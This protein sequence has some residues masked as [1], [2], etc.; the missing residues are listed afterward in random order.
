MINKK[1]IDDRIIDKMYNIKESCFVI[2]TSIG[3]LTIEKKDLQNSKDK[4]EYY[5]IEMKM[6][7]YKEDGKLFSTYYYLHR[8]YTGI[9]EYGGYGNRYIEYSIDIPNFEVFKNLNIDTY[10]YSRK[11]DEEICLYLNIEKTKY[12]SIKSDGVRLYDG[13]FVDE[14]YDIKDG[15]LAKIDNNYVSIDLKTSDIYININN[16]NLKIKIDKD[17]EEKFEMIT[18]KIDG[19]KKYVNTYMKDIKDILNIDFDLKDSM[20]KIINMKDCVKI[21]DEL[22]NARKIYLDGM[23]ILNYKHNPEIKREIAS[24]LNKYYSAKKTLVAN[25]IIDKKVTNNSLINRLIELNFGYYYLDTSYGLI[26]I[27]VSIDSIEVLYNNSIVFKMSKGLIKINT[28]IR[29]E[30]MGEIID[31]LDNVL[32]KERTIKKHNEEIDKQEEIKRLEKRLKELRG[33]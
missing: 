10:G 9:G 4:D 26:E 2:P 11:N 33:N 12:Y 17:L 18:S 7:I 31:Y 32:E 30:I 15:K 25:N 22:I 21:K 16:Y 23:K 14:F 19:L 27:D 29:N 5:N 24:N 28:G 3:N 6:D 8:D 13:N 20:G 1:T